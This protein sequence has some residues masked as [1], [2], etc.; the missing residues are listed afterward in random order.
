MERND[1]EI[2]RN[3]SYMGGGESDDEGAAVSIEVDEIVVPEEEHTDFKEK[4]VK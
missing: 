1:E 2:S 4:D 3:A